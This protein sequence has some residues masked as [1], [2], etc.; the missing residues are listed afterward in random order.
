[1]LR[2]IVTILISRFK[3][4]NDNGNLALKAV[5]PNWLIISD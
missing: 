1:M 2:G 3:F 5:K 4:I